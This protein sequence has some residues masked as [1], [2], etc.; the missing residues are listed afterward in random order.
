MKQPNSLIIIGGILIALLFFI[1]L[2]APIIASND[3]YKTDLLHRLKPPCPT[4]PLGTDQ[5]GRCVWS[6]IVY[7]SRVSLMASS[8]A[9]AFSVS[10]GFCIGM[11]AGFFSS[12]IDK[13]LMK[14]CDLFLAFPF[15]ILAIIF[16][17]IAGGSFKNLI[18]GIGVAGF[19]WWARFVRAMVLSAKQKDFVKA[20]AAMGAGN[21]RLILKYILPQILAPLLVSLSL[22]AGRMIVVISGL[23]YLGLGVQPPTPEWGNMLKEARIYMMQAPWLVIAPGMAVSF[24]VLAFNLIGEGLR[25]YFQ[26]KPAGNW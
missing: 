1:I 26:V 20:A 12:W 21:R 18:L 10:V 17:G 13:V 22:S 8:A 4:Y 16:S 9:I 15:M 23:S 11:A 3:P 19:A 24:S 2:A 6:R 14:I 5:L 25:D 7:G